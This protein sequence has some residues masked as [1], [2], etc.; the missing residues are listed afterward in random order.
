LFAPSYGFDYNVRYLIE[1]KNP[2]MN[3]NIQ[4]F[5]ESKTIAVVGASSA[6]KKFGNAVFRGLK[7][8]NY[9]V[10]P[11][12]PNAEEIEGDKSYP[13]LKSIP[14]DIEAAIVV[15]SPE[16]AEGVVEDALEKGVRKIWFQQGADFTRAVEKAEKAGLGVVS[17]KCIFLYAPPVSGGHAFHRFLVKLFGKL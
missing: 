4:S 15:T 12:N 3:P 13:D 11:V 10:Y 2:K 16:K 17:K 9:T 6:K 8:K 7:E 1:R 5:I 14:V